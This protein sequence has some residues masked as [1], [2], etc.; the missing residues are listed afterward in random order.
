MATNEDQIRELLATYGRSLNTSDAALAAT[1][2][3]ADGVFMP[4][5]LPTASGSDMEGAYGQIFEA[6]KAR[7]LDK[8]AAL[9][10]EHLD[11]FGKYFQD[12]NM[13][14]IQT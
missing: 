8:A 6:I 1:C 11:Y 13:T 14:D 7:D 4:T 5:T 12:L 3:T 10:A 2:Y 9:M